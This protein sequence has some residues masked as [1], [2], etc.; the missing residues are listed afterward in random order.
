MT[1]S[2]IHN[3]LLPSMSKALKQKKFAVGLVLIGLGMLLYLGLAVQRHSS[4]WIYISMGL[5]A[6]G[7]LLYAYVENLPFDVRFQRLYDTL[8]RPLNTRNYALSLLLCIAYIL[9]YFFPKY[10]GLGQGDQPNSGLIQYFDALSYSLNGHKSSQWFMYGCFYT[11][12]VLT[13]GIAVLWKRRKSAYQRLRTISVIFF[14]LIFAFL[15]PELL[16]RLNSPDQY[17][18]KDLK[19]MW[20]LNYSFFESWSLDHMLQGGEMGKFFLI[21]GLFLIFI[22]SPILTYYHGK[23]W[24][25]SW[26]CGCGGLAETAGDSFRSLADHSKAAWK[27]EVRLLYPILGFCLLMTAG[28]L[29]RYFTGSSTFLGFLDTYKMSQWYGFLIG[30]CFS[31][32]IGVGFYPILGSRVWCRFGCP[33]AAILGLQQKYLSRFRI[34]TNK[35]LCISCGQCT[36]SCE[37]G[38]DVRHYAQQGLSFKRASCVGCGLCS[39]VCPRGVLRLENGKDWKIEMDI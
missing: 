14:Q 24:Y 11:W 3:I 2:S 39:Y 28:V 10:L 33:M 4:A 31:G 38:I 21:W 8:W 26:V 5:I 23:R 20:P 6:A 15:I 32:V 1:N 13:W 16:S 9:L 34:S 25:C 19:L 27:L 36:R 22:L 18:N 30:A 7:V 17:Y 29:Y 12:A 37:M 35:D